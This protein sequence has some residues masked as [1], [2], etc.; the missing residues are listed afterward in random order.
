MHRDQRSEE[1]GKVLTAEGKSRGFSWLVHS[2]E[3]RWEEGESLVKAGVE[4]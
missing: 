3:H 4:A 2:L 1:V